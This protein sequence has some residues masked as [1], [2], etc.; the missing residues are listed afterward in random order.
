[1]PM[2][3]VPSVR[4]PA[5]P[6]PARQPWSV[7]RTSTI[8]T[9]WPNGKGTELHMIGRA[10]DLMTCGDVDAPCVVAEDSFIASLT[11]GREII[12]IDTQPAREGVDGL[13]GAQAGK[14]LRAAIAGSMAAELERGTPLYLL[15]DDI[16]GA[17]LVG[18][19]AWAQWQPDSIPSVSKGPGAEAQRRKMEGVCIGFSSDSPVMGGGEEDR[20]EHHQIVFPLDNTPDPLAWHVLPTQGGPAARRA[21]RIDVRM[22]DDKVVVDAHFQDS[23]TR[24]DGQRIAVHEYLLHA[25]IDRQTMLIEEI[26]ADPRVLPF[27]YCP[28]AVLHIGRMVG[29]PVSSLRT[30]VIRE[31]AREQGCTHLNDMLRSL[32]EVPQMVAPLV[33]AKAERA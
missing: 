19:V 22:E 12:Q 33:A 25:K 27:N 1:V 32:A 24:P 5:P 15:L 23:F 13:V 11:P 8:D 3:N 21:R 7:R 16:A 9:S 14:Q 2:T 17:S 20:T 18:I 26:A 4:G 10:R 31:L 30:N 28:A 6:T 29:T